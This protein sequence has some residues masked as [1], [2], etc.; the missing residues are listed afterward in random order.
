MSENDNNLRV[1]LIKE[2]EHFV[3]VHTFFDYTGNIYIE[4]VVKLVLFIDLL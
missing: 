1:F 2:L 4:N 3:V